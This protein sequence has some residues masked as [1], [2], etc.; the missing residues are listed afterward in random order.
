[1]K[2]LFPEMDREIALDRLAERRELRQ[3]AHDYLRDKQ[4]FQD[5][6]LKHLTEHGPSVD[7][8]VMLAMSELVEVGNLNET[9][10]V[11]L[12]TYAMWR[13]GKLW[14]KEFPNHPCNERCF[15]YGIK[16]IHPIP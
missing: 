10:K 13:T 12:V 15:T 8:N 14:R 7:A 16:G 9:L 3:R 5:F 2:T 1:M 4:G 6:I 11:M